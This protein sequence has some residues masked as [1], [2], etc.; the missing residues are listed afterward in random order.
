MTFLFK[1][2]K[3]KAFLIHCIEHRDSAKMKQLEKQFK[4]LSKKS[5]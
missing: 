4:K 3:I 2:T 1:K 5:I